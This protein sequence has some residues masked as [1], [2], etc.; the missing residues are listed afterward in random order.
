MATDHHSLVHNT[1][2][3]YIKTHMYEYIGYECPPE[4]IYQ[5]TKSI[6]K[7]LSKLDNWKD[8]NSMEITIRRGNYALALY[9]SVFKIKLYVGYNAYI[10][11]VNRKRSKHLYHTQYQCFETQG[12]L[13]EIHEWDHSPV[14]ADIFRDCKHANKYTHIIEQE[15][16]T[17]LISKFVFKPLRRGNLFYTRDPKAENIVYNPELDELFCI[18]YDYILKTSFSWYYRFVP[19]FIVD[20]VFGNDSHVNSQ[21]HNLDKEMMLREVK[22]RLLDEYNTITKRNN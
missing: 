13:V 14:L 11:K 3:D 17:S 7:K 21:L 22:E 8:F 18:D 19:D 6:L 4:I 9:N 1:I 2:Y 10:A 15:K 12:C 5:S 20:D 16:L